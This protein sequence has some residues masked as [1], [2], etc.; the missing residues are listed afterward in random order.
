MSNFIRKLT[1]GVTRRIVKKR[2]SPILTKYILE[3][4]PDNPFFGFSMKVGQDLSANPNEFFSHYDG[5]SFWTY[6]KIRDLHLQNCKILDIGSTKVLNAIMSYDHEVT[7]IVLANP[8]DSLSKVQYLEFDAGGGVP[9]PDN[10]FQIVTSTVS[11]HLIGLGRYSDRIDP[12]AIPFLI[13]ELD[14]VTGSNSYL[15]V[16][17]PIGRNELIFNGGYS[18][19]FS[20]FTDLFPNWKLVDFLVDNW[21]TP[22][23][24]NSSTRFTTSIDTKN[25]E[26][27]QYET[28]FF[29]F[30]KNEDES[31]S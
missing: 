14:R 4:K 15:F 6:S 27:G 23:F 1:D 11:L 9:F 30:Q 2:L 18:F 10:N 19:E 20:T 21:S 25:F 24:N 5:F 13:Q 17:I 8:H 31:S 28:V 7:A 26:S 3:M 12:Q 16:S 22:R 29:Q